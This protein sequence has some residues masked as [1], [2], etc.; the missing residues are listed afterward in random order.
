LFF[1]FGLQLAWWGAAVRGKQT[2]ALKQA[3]AADKKKPIAVISPQ[4]KDRSMKNTKTERL[5]KD[6]PSKTHSQEKRRSY[7]YAFAVG[8][9]GENS[10]SFG[11]NTQTFTYFYIM[12]KFF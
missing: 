7:L 10:L 1:V 3:G 9:I 4:K 6:P 11:I 8:L 12:C 5:T 2:M